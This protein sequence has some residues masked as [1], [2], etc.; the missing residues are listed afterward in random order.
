MFAPQQKI[1]D[2]CSASHDDIELVL[3]IVDAEQAYATLATQMTLFHFFFSCHD[4]FGPLIYLAGN[5]NLYPI[6]VGLNGFKGLYKGQ[7]NLIQAASLTAAIIPL[8][9]FF[10]AQRAFMQGVVITGV[11]K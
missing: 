4:F 5:P 10:F 9:V 3:E 6:T 8:V 2:D 7:D 11:E 1:V